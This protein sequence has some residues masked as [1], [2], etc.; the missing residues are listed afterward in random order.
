MKEDAMTP[1]PPTAPEVASLPMASLPMERVLY[2]VEDQVAVISLN[3]PERHNAIG[4]QMAAEYARAME[5][6]MSDPQVRAIVLRGEGRSFC[7]GKD[8]SELG[9]R[10]PGISNYAHVRNSQKRKF[11]ALDS[12]KPI[13][14]AVRGYAIGGG[15]EMALLADIRVA[16]ESVKFGLPEINHG[17]MT[18]GG[19]TAITAAIAGPA[20][21][22]YMVMTGELVDGKTAMQWGLVEFLVPDEEVDAL[23]LS[24]AKKIAAQPPVH[25]QVAKRLCEAVHGDGI[26]RGIQEELLAISLLYST[27]DREETRAARREGR[28]PK[29]T[30]L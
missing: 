24:I 30:G 22:K 28:K 26:R 21:A 17:I 23:A 6:A 1:Q 25:I 9:V 20:R 19:G 8:V 10:A 5:Q 14:A 27:Q 13:V 3:N 12:P 29:F 2:R 16:G 11:E 18:D 7:S 4:G 15:C